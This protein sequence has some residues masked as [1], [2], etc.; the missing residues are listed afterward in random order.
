MEMKLGNSNWELIFT[1]R[2]V[3]GICAVFISLGHI[4]TILAGAVLLFWGLID[5]KFEDKE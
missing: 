3:M 4:P 2:E 1:V 5:R